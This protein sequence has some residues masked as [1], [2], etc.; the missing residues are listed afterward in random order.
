[1]DDNQAV[2]GP[3]S[4]GSD[5]SWTARELAVGQLVLNQL[6]R[7][8]RQVNG[9]FESLVILSVLQLQS[10]GRALRE[11]PVSCAAAP[12]FLPASLLRH[13][14]LR[15]SDLAQS[16]GIPRETVRRKLERMQ[17]EGKVVRHPD[18]RWHVRANA[19][20]LRALAR[21]MLDSAN[22]LSAV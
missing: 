10:A 14:G 7:M 18:G 9:D 11:D 2:D 12:V 17:S 8:A 20:E 6:L 4:V 19:H 21:Q 22:A 1:M 13:Q 3:A 5:G 15:S 16:T